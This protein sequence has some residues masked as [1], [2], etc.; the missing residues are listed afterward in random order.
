MHLT[1]RQYAFAR[2]LDGVRVIVTVNNDDNEAWMNLPAG[3]AAEY[4]GTLTG[5]RVAVEGGHINVCVGANSGEIWVPAGNLEEYQPFK[6]EFSMR[7]ETVEPE[8]VAEV[9]A[10]ETSVP[11]IFSENRNSIVEETPVPQ[12]EVNNEEATE[13]KASPAASVQEA[14]STKEDTA[15]TPASAEKEPVNYDPNKAPEDMTIEELQ[16]GIL[17]KMANNGP[18][19]DQMKKTVSDNIWHDSLVNWIKSFR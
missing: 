19:T 14:A 4:V 12:K 8:S 2:D 3:N 17:A 13:T 18:V 11:E 7:E 1:N 10:E 6:A 16:A 9:P 5:Q 15:E